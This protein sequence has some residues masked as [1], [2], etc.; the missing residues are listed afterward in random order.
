[1][2]S[3]QSLNQVVQNSSSG[4]SVSS[5]NLTPTLG[6]GS[7][8]SKLSSFQPNNIPLSGGGPYGG[9]KQQAALTTNSSALLNNSNSNSH[10]FKHSTS[11]NMTGLSHASS[12]IVHRQGS[13]SGSSS[14]VNA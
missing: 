7:Q 2:S 5:S 13:S 3:S 10:S 14:A 12:K 8:K 4:A 6:V 11:S 1:M 9:R